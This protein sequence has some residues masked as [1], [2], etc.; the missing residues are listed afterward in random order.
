[1][2]SCYSILRVELPGQSAFRDSVLCAAWHLSEVMAF[3]RSQRNI[4]PVLSLW[5]HY[6]LISVGFQGSTAFYPQSP[7]ADYIDVHEYHETEELRR[8]PQ[9]L[10]GDDNLLT[11]SC[12]AT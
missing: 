6:I 11:G 7:E 5:F 2:L 8:L 1:M 4:W 3:S 12:F 9:A 10:R